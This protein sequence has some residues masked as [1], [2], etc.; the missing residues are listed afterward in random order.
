MTIKKSYFWLIATRKRAVTL[1]GMP[2][3]DHFA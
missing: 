1:N 3:G 2:S